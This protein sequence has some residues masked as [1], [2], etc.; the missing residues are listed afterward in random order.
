MNLSLIGILSYGVGN[1]GF[2]MDHASQEF[3]NY[4]RP[5]WRRLH[6][7]ARQYV[8]LADAPDLVQETLLRAWRNFSPAGDRVYQRAWL[9]V[10]LRNVVLEWQRTAR[11]RI[12]LTVVSDTELT[13]VAS[14]DPGELLAA[15][16]AMNEAQFREL[17]DD[18]LAAAL[19]AL[20]PV[21]REV[22]VLS[23]AGDLSYREI[24]EVLGCPVGTV[25]SRMG[26]ARRF[27]RERL[28]EYAGTRG[29]RQ[30]GIR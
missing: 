19:D 1:S 4:V 13:E 30:G 14:S 18:R 10:I 9:L 6:L 28:A 23:V 20:E 11:R 27:L 5:H 22:L 15:I 2:D 25:M 26:R 17:L 12:R 24:A 21:Y 16:P 8:A 3:L 7:I 29:Q